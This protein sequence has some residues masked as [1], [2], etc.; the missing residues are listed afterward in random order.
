MTKNK[1]RSFS[2]GDAYSPEWV[3]QAAIK[4]NPNARVSVFVRLPESLWKY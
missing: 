3:E 4:F 1:I 2:Y